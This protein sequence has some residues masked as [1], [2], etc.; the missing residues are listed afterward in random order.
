LE[1]FKKLQGNLEFHQNKCHPRNVLDTRR[2]YTKAANKWAQGVV[3]R[4]GFMS[5]W[6]AASCTR[7]YTRRGRQRQWR[8]LVE[9]KPHGRVETWL[10]W[11]ATTWRVTDLTKLVTPPWTPINT[12]SLVEIRT[13]T[14]FW[15][16][17]LQSSYS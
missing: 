5:V 11:P 8:K 15:R 13:H 16:F 9:A 3:G 2:K 7:L 17:H 1:H 14:T 4:P 6:P 10:C 12:P